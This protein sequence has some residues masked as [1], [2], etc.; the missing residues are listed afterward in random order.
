MEKTKYTEPKEY[1]PK[2]IRKKL[3]LGEF[4][5]EAEKEDKKEQDR[6]NKELRRVFKGK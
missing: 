1:I 2:E 3:G 5:K 6:E 4:S